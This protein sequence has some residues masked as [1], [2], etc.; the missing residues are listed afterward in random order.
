VS[1]FPQPANS[2]V[3]YGERPYL[4]VWIDRE[5][6]MDLDPDQAPMM[7]LHFDAINCY[8]DGEDC[9]PFEAPAVA[10][11]TAAQARGLIR[12]IDHLATELEKVTV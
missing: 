2:H 11:L 5:L 6:N 8:T 3:V 9:L 12:I 1:F 10:T 7:T 4:V